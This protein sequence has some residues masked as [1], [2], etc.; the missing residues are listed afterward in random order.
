MPQDALHADQPI[1]SDI[2]QADG[3]EQQREEKEG[4]GT[5]NEPPVGSAKVCIMRTT[6]DQGK[7]LGTLRGSFPLLIIM[8]Y[9][10][11]GQIAFLRAPINNKI[12]LN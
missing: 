10:N 12:S 6:A 11:D 2:M 1:H 9:D 7:V 5:H 8:T 3:S 4:D